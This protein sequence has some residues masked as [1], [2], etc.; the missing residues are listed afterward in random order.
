MTIPL[1]IADKAILAARPA[2][3][4]VD[5]RRPYAYLVEPEY[6]ADGEVEDVAVVFLT[7]KEC[8]FRCLM[9]DLWMNT[10]DAAVPIGAIPE[11]IDFALGQLAPARH[12]KLYNSGNFFDP[13]A[14][15]PQDY[16]AIIERTAGF[17]TTIVENHP[18]M[19]GDRLR[20][21]VS[22]MKAA[23][24]LSQL[25]V[26]MGLE[27][28]HPRVLPL[29]NKRMTTDSFRTACETL[30]SLGV[31]I[32]AFVLLRP[33]TLSDQEGLEWAVRSMEFA[34][35]AGAGVV[36]VIPT[37]AGNGMMERLQSEELF[38]PPSLSSL[39]AVLEAGL[40]MNRGRVFVDLWDA[41]SL[42]QEQGS[43]SD[44]KRELALRIER[45]R[46][47]NLCQRVLPKASM[48]T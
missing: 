30:Q 28:I 12:I 32:R 6:Q 33:P 17:S 46:Q 41:A 24:S 13:S 5:P 27:T 39:E 19:C 14:I 18:R 22:A 35:A 1:R 21:F 10:T 2:K 20:Q 38:S 34:F 23:E 29:L 42:F 3:R 4:A 43:T 44:G 37:R 47:M 7:N 9:C 45:L 25:E 8:P 16:A 26:A 15:P 36:S 48:T 31:A 11:Q 40:S